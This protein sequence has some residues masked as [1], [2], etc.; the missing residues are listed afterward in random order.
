MIITAYAAQ[1][2]V[3]RIAPHFTIEQAR[4]ARGL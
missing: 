4:W 1:R 2:Y 3:E